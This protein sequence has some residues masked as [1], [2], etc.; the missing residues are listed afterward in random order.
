[1]R[2][3]VTGPRIWKDSYV[4]AVAFDDILHAAYYNLADIPPYSV[5]IV[6]GGAAG[7]DKM[8]AEEARLREWQVEEVRPDYDK[9]PPKVAPTMRNQAMVDLGAWACLAFLMPCDKLACRRSKR[10]H[11]THGTSDCMTRAKKA[12]IP[13]W[14][15]TPYVD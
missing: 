11:W 2:I 9:Y 3:L 1:M 8:A 7:L 4:V 14:K 6:H 5:T 10:P 13:V 12:G 15:Y